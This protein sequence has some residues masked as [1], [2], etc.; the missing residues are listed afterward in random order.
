MKK[1]VFALGVAGFAA[2]PALAAEMEFAQVDTDNSDLV[3]T[4]ELEAASLEL[5]EEEFA[6]ADAD[7]DGYLNAEE[8][9]VAVANVQ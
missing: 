8:F 5:S 1:L 6:A 2:M 3:S 9:A 4:E 7:A